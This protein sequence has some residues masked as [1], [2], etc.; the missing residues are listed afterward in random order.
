MKVALELDK[1]STEVNKANIDYLR[2]KKLDRF[3]ELLSQTNA[4][5]TH[6]NIEIRVAI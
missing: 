6:D 2:L 1:D 3:A 4:E 5:K